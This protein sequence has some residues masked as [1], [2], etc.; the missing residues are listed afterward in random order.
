MQGIRNP[1]NDWDPES[2][3]HWQRIRNPESKTVSDSFKWGE[4]PSGVKFGYIL[5]S[6]S[7]Y[8]NR[9]NSLRLDAFVSFFWT[10][11]VHT[12]NSIPIILNEQYNVQ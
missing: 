11:I 9:Q 3:F 6:S 10:L 4:N 2:K 5:K 8:E 12:L 7:G 1:T